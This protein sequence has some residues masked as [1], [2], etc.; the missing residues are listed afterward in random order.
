MIKLTLVMTEQEAE[1]LLELVRV[2][3]G[4]PRGPR[5]F[6]DEI[7]NALICVGVEKH[8]YHGRV[9][10]ESGNICLVDNWP[11]RN[12]GRITCKRL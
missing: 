7:A 8:G 12:E 10:I 11:T 4:S 1:A 9:Y 3:G 2:I 6:T 5:G